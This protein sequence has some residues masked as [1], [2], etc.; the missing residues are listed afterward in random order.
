MP[1]S[2][3]PAP[4]GRNGGPWQDYPPA[5]DA[6]QPGP[7]PP[8][9]PPERL[10]GRRWNALARRRRLLAGLLAAVVLMLAAGVT[11]HA[12]LSHAAAK[13]SPDGTA[14]QAFRIE[15]EAR[16]QA[17]LWVSRQVSRRVVVSCDRSMCAALRVD[18]IPVAN[19]LILGKRARDL[20]RSAVI[21]ATPS[22]RRQFGDRLESAYAPA[23]I[24]SFGTGYL[25]IE[26][27]AIAP[28]GAVAYRSVLS[29]DLTARRASGIQLARSNRIE[30]A[31][32]VLRQLSAG[33][34]DSRLLVTIAGMAA[35][36][37]VQIVALG[38]PDPGASASP[39][40]SAELAAADTAA[41]PDN[42]A[43]LRPML[44]YVHGQQ[45]P[46]L[47]ARTQ[48]LRLANGRVALRIEFAAPSPL[49]LLG[50]QA[51]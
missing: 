46:Y 12:L 40:R 30:A 21:V 15:A 5:D 25:R 49:G 11:M 51:P 8:G 13:T 26:V 7:R 36:Q 39:I 19:L 29:A 33:A 47:A 22:L 16:H 42:A 41:G 6:G 50:P 24:A 45:G 23:L 35:L 3:V 37:P 31:A 43:F 27:R 18:G 4:A 2:D 20:L 1:D 44:A 14:S 28:H 9:R 34:V 17:A 38:S 48:T 10:P 32:K